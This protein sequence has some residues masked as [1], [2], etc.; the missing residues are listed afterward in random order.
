M[1]KN[2]QLDDELIKLETKKIEIMFLKNNYNLE[3]K[4]T[5]INLKLEEA[6]KTNNINLLEVCKNI[7]NNMNV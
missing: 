1:L 4:K 3:K 6:K 5:Y 2:N 7:I